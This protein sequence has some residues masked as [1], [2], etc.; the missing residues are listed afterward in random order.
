M[1]GDTR[2][3]SPSA[4]NPESSSKIRPYH[5]QIY[6]TFNIP[7]PPE[8][9]NALPGGNA[10]TAGGHPKEVGIIDALKTV[11]L[12]EFAEVHRKPCVRDALL[13]GIGIGFGV[14]GLRGILGGRSPGYPHVTSWD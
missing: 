13:T 5:G 2:N 10:N 14:G 7:T 8:N 11:N 3:S 6:E 4:S 1:P 12:E 9:A